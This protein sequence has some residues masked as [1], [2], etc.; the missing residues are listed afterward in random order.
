MW[1]VLLVNVISC[2]VAIIKS[3]K[4]HSHQGQQ[5][6]NLFSVLLWN[7]I[8]LLHLCQSYCS[9]VSSDTLLDSQQMVKC[10]QSAAGHQNHAKIWSVTCTLELLS[11]KNEEHF[12]RTPSVRSEELSKLLMKSISWQRA[13]LFTRSA[14]MI[15]SGSWLN[16]RNLQWMKI[17]HLSVPLLVWG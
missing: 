17:C 11:L 1:F 16:T 8:F 6:K 7:K 15:K 13:I 4:T 9:H 10:K 14:T 5:L 3:I 12:N 2:N